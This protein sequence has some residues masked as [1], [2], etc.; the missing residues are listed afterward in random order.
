MHDETVSDTQHSRK[1]GGLRK[2]LFPLIEGYSLEWRESSSLW[3]TKVYEYCTH[4]IMIILLLQVFM[5]I[6]LTL[7]MFGF[8]NN[9]ISYRIRLRILVGSRLSR[10]RFRVSD[11]WVCTH[12]LS[13]NSP[14]NCL[15]IH[16]KLILE[17]AIRSCISMSRLDLRSK[18]LLQRSLLSVDPYT[19]QRIKCIRN[20]S[21]CNCFHSIIC[22]WTLGANVSIHW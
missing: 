9:R 1:R 5:K 8:L 18:A 13:S 22:D 14:C 15:M 12:R 4:S 21:S 2:V 17:R 10:M 16:K 19:S 6:P 7:S 11:M 3:H 20:S